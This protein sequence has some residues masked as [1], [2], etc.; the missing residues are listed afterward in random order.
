MAASVHRDPVAV[1]D[2]EV[3]QGER[4]APRFAL[5]PARGQEL[6]GFLGELAKFYLL[7]VNGT[8]LLTTRAAMEMKLIAVMLTINFLFDLAV[9]TSL[10]NMVFHTGK[11]TLGLLSIPALFCGLLFSAIIFVYERQFMTA[12]TYHRLKK[13]V[14]PVMI[15]LGIIVTAAAVTTQPFEVM[16]F[17]GPVQ[18]RIH[19]ES[20]RVEALSRLR[21]LEEAALKTRGAI[22]LKDT[23]A[24]KS[25]QDAKDELQHTREQTSKFTAEAQ[26]AR[27]EQQAAENAMR[28][29][30]QQLTRARTPGQAAAA[31]RRYAAAQARSEQARISAEN[32]E[33][34]A[35]TSKDNEKPRADDVK[36]AEGAIEA[37]EQIAEKDVKRLQ[38]W[39]TQIRNAK[40]GERVIE[41]R[42][43]SPKWEYQDQDYDF[44]QRLGVINDLYYGR[45]ARWLEINSQ[46]REKLSKAY[47]LTEVDAN[48]T[49]NKDRT[50]ADARTFRWSYWAVIGVAAIIPFLL[51]ALKG[52][53]PIDLKRY[54]STE[55]QQSAGNYETLRFSSLQLSAQFESKGARHN[56]NYSGAFRKEDPE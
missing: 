20:V 35:K 15:R 12:D 1:T 25:L 40:A 17:D 34:Q 28:S 13:V 48:D 56:G 53:L 26:A 50:A 2:R 42:A 32:F 49:L 14:F 55:A 33:A 31:R 10:W 30:S 37:K 22:G 24:G 54:Y 29:A 41:N 11:L 19:E 3:S 9:W 45:P 43:E 46:D 5:A 38:D 21:A 36:A 47:G 23:I 4:R 6:N 7:N 8:S 52:L 16:V 44:F 18:R 39:V 51:L 27:A